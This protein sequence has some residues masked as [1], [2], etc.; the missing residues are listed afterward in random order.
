MII[1]SVGRRTSSN[2]EVFCR[3]LY[4]NMDSLVLH[5]MVLFAISLILMCKAQ[6]DKTLIA[7]D[8]GPDVVRAVIGRIQESYIFPS[9]KQFLRRI[10][11]T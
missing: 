11:P 10:S 6:V 7:E 5:V 3:R 8:S 2:T 1:C 4:T 9:D